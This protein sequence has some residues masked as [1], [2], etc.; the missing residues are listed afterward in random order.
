MATRTIYFVRHGEYDWQAQPP[1]LKRLTPLGKKQAQLTAKRLRSLPVTAIYSSDLIRAVETAEIIRRNHDGIPYAK[2]RVLR[3][4]ALPSP[5][6]FK[7][8]SEERL[9]AGQKQ[10]AAA[11]SSF[12]RPARGHDKHEII[13]CHGNLIRYLVSRLLVDSG[14]NWSRMGT[15]NCGISKVVIKSDG[16]MRVI[17]YNDIG[18]LPLQPPK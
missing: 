1:S 3:E 14:D 12:L 6:S 17:T 10:A 16:R 8:V 9:R 11:F 18:H 2:R 5:Y 7:N 13:V 15:S 4:C